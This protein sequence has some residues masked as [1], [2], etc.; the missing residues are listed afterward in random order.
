MSVVLL[1][2]KIIGILLLAV[3]GL[4]L[5]VIL[6]VLLAPVR[7]R[8]RASSGPEL[9]V[10]ANLRWLFPLVAFSLGYE[11]RKLSQKLRILGIPVSIGGKGGGAPPKPS[12]TKKKKLSPERSESTAKAEAAQQG[13]AAKE[14]AS[15]QEPVTE[16]KAAQQEAGALHESMAEGDARNEHKKPG[17]LGA[18]FKKVKAMPRMIKEKVAKLKE[19]ALRIYREIR[20]ETN[21]N[22][23]RLLLRELWTLVGHYLPRKLK[24]DVQ[25]GMADPAAT[26][27]ILGALSLFPVFL[28]PGVRIVPDFMA[29]KIYVT[30]SLEMSGHVR[31][32]HVVVAALH[33]WKERDV[34]KLI[35]RVR[36]RR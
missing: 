22:V 7:Y 17:R 1:V 14:T 21:Q 25:F 8:I 4:A 20:D 35:Q 19:I 9:S 15:G 27:Q 32:I 30:G 28:R 12:H 6:S 29:E 26:G 11:E 13:H 33:L 2:L 10:K 16:A 24:A 18:L 36:N 23:L 34:K 3:L 5:L 31:A